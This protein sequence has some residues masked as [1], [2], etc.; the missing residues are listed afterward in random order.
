MVTGMKIYDAE[1]F[2]IA[3]NAEIRTK[4]AYEKM[5]SLTKSDIIRDELLFL[6]KEEDKHKQIIKRMMERFGSRER[7][8][9]MIELKAMGEFKVITEKMAEVVSKQDLNLDEVYEIAM[10]AEKASETLY[11]ELSQFAANEETKLLLNM[12]ADMEVNHYNILKKQYEYIMQYPDVYKEE[13][14]EQLMKEI[15][16]NF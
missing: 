6:A 4:E 2:D 8:P 10:Q 7:E 11:R 9:V 1:V 5:A 14:Y 16:F 13:F 3:L 12:L 15:N